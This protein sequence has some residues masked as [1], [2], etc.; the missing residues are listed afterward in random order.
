MRNLRRWSPCRGGRDRASGTLAGCQRRSVKAEIAE[1]TGDPFRG[2][3]FPL[4]AIV[5]AA[6]LGCRR[7]GRSGRDTYHSRW[8]RKLTS[9]QEAAIR[10]DTGNR[11]LRELVAEFCVRHELVRTVMRERDVLRRT[12]MQGL[13]AHPDGEPSF[14]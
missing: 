14:Q 11:T 3:N 6:P 4:G 2:R 9:E 5:F 8:R 7:A 12:G 10:A 1:A 13:E